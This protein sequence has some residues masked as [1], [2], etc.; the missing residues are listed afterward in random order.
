MYFIKFCRGAPLDFPLSIEILSYVF[1]KLLDSNRVLGLHSRQVRF[2]LSDFTCLW[3]NNVSGNWFVILSAHD[4]WH[5]DQWH[6]GRIFKSM[7]VID[8]FGSNGIFLFLHIP[9]LTN[10]ITKW[11]FTNRNDSKSSLT[12]IPTPIG[13]PEKY[14]E[15]RI[16]T[17]FRWE[18]PWKQSQQWSEYSLIT[19]I[20][21]C[22]QNF[23]SRGW[24]TIGKPGVSS[25]FFSSLMTEFIAP[26]L[27]FRQLSFRLSDAEISQQILWSK[28]IDRIQWDYQSHVFRHSD[29]ARMSRC[30]N[31][32]TIWPIS[33]SSWIQISILQSCRKSPTIF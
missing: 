4:M 20:G 26:H 22:H 29:I 11:Q 31:L 18:M 12:R 33:E 14:R 9:Q 3:H 32:K 16:R 19:K 15:I 7:S 24:I 13:W 2:R 5:F 25:N 8:S 28:Q 21:L 1:E 6:E 10:L 23:E 17:A 27:F 30:T